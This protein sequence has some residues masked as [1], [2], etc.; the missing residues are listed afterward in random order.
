MNPVNTFTIDFQKTKVVG[1]CRV[2]KFILKKDEIEE[3]YPFIFTKEGTTHFGHSGNH[4]TPEEAIVA[5]LKSYPGNEVKIE[6][7]GK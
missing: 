7:V 1:I 2:G 4:K 6:I 5:F 3:E